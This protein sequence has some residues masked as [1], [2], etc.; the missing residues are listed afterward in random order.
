MKPNRTFLENSIT[1]HAPIETVW[2]YL[3]DFRNVPQWHKNM[4]KSEWKGEP[5]YG[6]GS[7]YEW[8]E[9]SFGVRMDIGGNITHWDAPYCYEWEPK[10]N[11]YNM[12]GGW[13]L[14]KSGKSTLVVR[15]SYTEL[16]GFFKYFSFLIL[17]I[18]KKQVRMEME[19]LK[20]LLET[21]H[22]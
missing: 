15:Y 2:A 21:T 3:T 8:I 13:K 22:Q 14:S 10:I 18:V 7:E 16:K 1:I 6:V 4:I 11:P 5:P 12:S 17:P 20:Q 19:K 9:T